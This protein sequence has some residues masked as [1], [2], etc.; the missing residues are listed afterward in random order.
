MFFLCNKHRA[1]FDADP[2]MAI[3]KWDH[4][5]KKAIALFEKQHYRQSIPFIGAGFDIA[6][7]LVRKCDSDT[8]ELSSYDRLLLAG[9]ALAECYRRLGDIT[10]ERRF[11][12]ATHYYLMNE[13]QKEPFN[14][15]LLIQPLEISL[16]TLKAHYEAHDEFSQFDHCYKRDSEKLEKISRPVLH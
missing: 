15:Q 3:D 1:I 7:L 8:S 13:L 9:H 2:E 11:L 12:L 16:R 6:T 4:C 5:M 10:A 14:T